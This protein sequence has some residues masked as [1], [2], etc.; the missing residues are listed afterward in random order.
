MSTLSAQ[1]V[2][3][4][5]GPS[6]PVPSSPLPS[7]KLDADEWYLKD[8]ECEWECTYCGV[9]NERADDFCDNCDEYHDV[10]L[11]HSYRA[12]ADFGDAYTGRTVLITSGRGQGQMR[13]ITSYTD[14]NDFTISPPWDQ[15]PDSSSTFLI[16]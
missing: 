13:T 2:R 7:D 11:S 3:F 4:P 12:E 15:Q 9:A 5:H 10:G 1:P 8:P 6:Y 16:T 14:I